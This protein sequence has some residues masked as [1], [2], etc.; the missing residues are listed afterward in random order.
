LAG[1]SFTQAWARGASLS[2]EQA[3]ALALA[4]PEPGRQPERSSAGERGATPLTPRELAVARRIERGLTNRQIAA[5]LVI[6]EGTADRHVANILGKLGFT[7]RAQVAAWVARSA[8]RTGAE[9]AEPA[10]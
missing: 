3:V 4:L 2:V 5:D 1:A 9:P 7:S 8:V 10:T 6:A